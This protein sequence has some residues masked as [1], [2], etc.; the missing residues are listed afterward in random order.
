VT[1]WVVVGA[2]SVGILGGIVGLIVG[3]LAYAPTAPFAVVELGLPATLAG[4]LLG[5]MAGLVVAAGRRVTQGYR[6][7]VA[8]TDIP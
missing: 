5:L 8:P 2:V 1:R 4:G 3:L 7:A 6:R